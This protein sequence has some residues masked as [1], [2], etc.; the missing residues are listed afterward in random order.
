MDIGRLLNRSWEAFIRQPVNL[1][2]FYVVGALLMCIPFLNLVI[3]GGL[4]KGIMKAVRGEDVNINDLFSEMDR[5]GEWIIGGILAGL[6]IG[7]GMVLLF[8]PGIIL[9][10]LLS[11]FMYIMV[12][13]RIGFMDAF[14]ESWTITSKNIGSWLIVLIIIGVL[15]ALGGMVAIGWIITGPISMLFGIMA[16]QEIVGISAGVYTGAPAYDPNQTPPPPPPSEG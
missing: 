12:D 11:M 13:K 7:L 14:K 3:L 4:I 1:L 2:I 16:Y 9:A 10:F 15:N 6:A 8:I 5:A